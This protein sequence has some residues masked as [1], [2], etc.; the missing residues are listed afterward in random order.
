MTRAHRVLFLFVLAALA[1]PRVAHA[2]EERVHLD[3]DAPSPCPTADG[4]VRQVRAY[5]S[6]WT[7]AQPD[8]QRRRFRVRIVHD[9]EGYGGTFELDAAPPRAIRGRTCD[10]VVIG[11]AVVVGLALDPE[12]APSAPAAA[13]PPAARRDPPAPPSA[14]AAPSAYRPSLSADA[15]VGVTTAIS[16][17]LA[18][19]VGGLSL[20]A[21]W[22]AERRFGWAPALRVGVDA[23]LP[24][25]K[26][27]GETRAEVAWVAARVEGC[28]AQI[29]L[30]ERVRVTAC[31]DAHVGG[32]LADS[33]N[34]PGAKGQRRL[35][36]DWGVA[37]PVRWTP[38]RRVFLEARAA[39]MFPVTRDRL[40]VEPDG[41]LT[42]APIAGATVSLGAG[43]IF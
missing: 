41:L 3:Y 42:V 10:E 9:E 30:G 15:E 25:D 5:A 21:Q 43:V 37:I 28:P 8:E 23:A 12:S 31:L 14:P 26:T 13:P 34:V 22:L 32:L 4:F 20:E 29:V 2:E 27:V 1:I 6:S 19:A 16:S 39:A 7:I 38:F 36:L 35:W 11:L 33:Q 24:R 17:S 40:H 18:L